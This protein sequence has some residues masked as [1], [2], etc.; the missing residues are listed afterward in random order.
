MLIR[1]CHLDVLSGD[2]AG[3]R[4]GKA[5]FLCLWCVIAASV[6]MRIFCTSAICLS[7]LSLT[8]QDVTGESQRG[9]LA[10]METKALLR[11][12]ASW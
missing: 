9:L 5:I 12:I 6:E 7:I 3:R 8:C 4:E 1:S 10:I 2:L 11:R